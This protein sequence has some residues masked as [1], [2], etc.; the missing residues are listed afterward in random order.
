MSAPSNLLNFCGDYD[1][2]VAIAKKVNRI[3]VFDFFS[4]TCPP[5]KMLLGQLPSI[6]QQF[7]KLL[8][9]KCDV[10][11]N[12]SIAQKYG[13]TSVPTIKFFKLNGD[14][15]QELAQVLGADVNSIRQYCTNF[16]N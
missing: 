2:L 11:E 13:I 5:C 14:N 12:Q 4:Q 9:L 10:N 6:A 3:I 16:S 1:T 15:L 8:F 7:N